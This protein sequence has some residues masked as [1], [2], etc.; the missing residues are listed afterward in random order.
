MNKSYY[1]IVKFGI[2]KFTKRCDGDTLM[3][4]YYG[5]LNSQFPP[6]IENYFLEIKEIHNNIMKETTLYNKIKRKLR[7]FIKKIQ[8]F[9]I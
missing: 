1:N 7:N 8:V 4:A 5:F 2:K 6:M 3:A 9:F